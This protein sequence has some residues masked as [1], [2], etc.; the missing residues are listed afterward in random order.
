[1]KTSHISLSK[2]VF[3][4]VLAIG[5]CTATSVLRAQT[6]SPTQIVIPAVSFGGADLSMLTNHAALVGYAFKRVQSVQAQVSC[7]GQVGGDG[8]TRTYPYTNAVKSIDDIMSSL[9][10]NE[11]WHLQNVSNTDYV[12][13]YVQLN[14]GPDANGQINPLFY[15]NNGGQP[16]QNQYG[17]WVMPS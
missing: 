17:Q 15:G 10:L 2:A 7:N 5:L 12:N 16:V 14:D 9:L 4:A 1:M 6:I 3:S 11:H 8:S 13:L